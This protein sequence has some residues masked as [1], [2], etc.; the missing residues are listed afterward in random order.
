MELI[1]RRAA[2]FAGVQSLTLHFPGNTSDGEED[3]TRV[4]YIGLRGKAAP[5][6]G[7]LRLLTDPLQLPERPGIILYESAARPTDHKVEQRLM[8]GN[9][10]RP[11]Y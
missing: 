4:Y 3:T 11:G 5:V 7:S 2:K 8:E 10:Y 9:T 1:C 6:S